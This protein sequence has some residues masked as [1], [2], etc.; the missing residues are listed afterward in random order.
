[1]AGFSAGIMILPVAFAITLG[2]SIILGLPVA[3]LYRAKRWKRLSTAVIGAAL[4]GAVPGGVLTWPLRPSSRTT[5][6]VGGVPTIIDGV[7]TFAGWLGYLELLAMLGGLG[8]VGGLV[9]WLTL[10]WSGVLTVTDPDPVKRE[11]RQRRIGFLFAGTAVVASVAI[12]ALPSI[13]KDGSCHNMFRDGRRSASPKMNIDLDI[14]TSDWLRLAQ[15]LERFGASH[16]MSFR[17]TSETRPAVVEILGP[18]ACTEA[19]VVISIIE[20]R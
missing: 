2:H 10:R 12:F 4:I 7:P 18:S 11:F 3:L 19:G 5:A 8:A 14:T 15:L 1:V 13:L 9:I 16:G 6:S 17:N 20:Q